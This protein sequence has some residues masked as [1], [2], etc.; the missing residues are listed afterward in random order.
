MIAEEEVGI[1]YYSVSTPSTV[2]IL[3]ILLLLAF[4]FQLHSYPTSSVMIMNSCCFSE[5]I[6][7]VVTKKPEYSN[8]MN[9]AVKSNKTIVKVY[10]NYI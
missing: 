1:I 8:D 10:H 2:E 9:I 5:L 4:N 6:G 3:L 7:S